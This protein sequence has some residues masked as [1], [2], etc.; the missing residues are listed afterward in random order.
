MHRIAFTMCL[1]LTASFVM[2]PHAN[3]ENKPRVVSI[4]VCT[5]QMLLALADPEQILSLTFLSH[6]ESASVHREKALQYPT[7]KGIAEEALALKPDLV[8][9]GAFTS[10]YTLQLLQRAGMQVKS[11]NIASSIEEVIET[12][13]EVGRWLQQEERAQALVNDMNARLA[14]LPTVPNARPRAAIYDP[15]GY[16]VGGG[17]LR[18]QSLELAGWYNVA[19]DRGIEQYGNLALET[20][21]TLA[22]DVL[23]SSPY[24]E[25]TWS[26]GQTI[27]KHPALLQSGLRAD[28]I[29]VPSAKTICGGPWTVDVIEQLAQ[30]RQNFQTK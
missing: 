14:K 23:I 19:V 5:D 16:T 9:A 1:L 30:V 28:V 20:L 17:T 22:P 13:T 26:R 10:K 3:A 8:L 6:N 27:N 15:R 24:S 29:K 4:N 2:A 12:L 7:N 21:L 25:G 18:G 11:V